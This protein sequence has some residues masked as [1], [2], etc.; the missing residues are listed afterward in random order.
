MQSLG[1]WW[2][3]ARSFWPGW[4]SAAICQQ[5]WIFGVFVLKH[6]S[7]IRR[8]KR[9]WEWDMIDM[10]RRKP[11]FKS[12]RKTAVRHEAAM[13]QTSSQYFQKVAGSV[14]RGTSSSCLPEM[15]VR[16]FAQSH[17]GITLQGGWMA[18]IS[19]RE[20]SQISQEKLT[21]W[22]VSASWNV[23]GPIGVFWGEGGGSY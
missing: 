18:E 1:V 19:K 5:L 22:I 20:F 10:A 4:Q 9:E 2:C 12:D 23:T 15:I 17:N 14:H 8:R 7:C 11:T 13:Q 3:H 6:H 16:E 21:F